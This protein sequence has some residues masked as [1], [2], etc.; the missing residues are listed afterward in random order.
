MTSNPANFFFQEH[1]GGLGWALG[2]DVWER[3]IKFYDYVKSPLVNYAWDAQISRIF[4][5]GRGNLC[6]YPEIP[7]SYHG[8]IKSTGTSVMQR[9]W[10]ENMILNN[11]SNVSYRIQELQ[12]MDHHIQSQIEAGV[13]VDCV[14]DILSYH[15]TSVVIFLSASSNFDVNWKQIGN[16]FSNMAL[17]VGEK[18]MRAV[19]KVTTQ[20]VWGTNRVLIV[21]SGSPFAHLVSTKFMARPHQVIATTCNVKTDKYWVEPYQHLFFKEIGNPDE[22]CH[23]TCAKKHQ[24]CDVHY[25]HHVTL[26]LKK[27]NPSGNIG[28]S[29]NHI[30]YAYPMMSPGQDVIF[31]SCARW[32]NCS[33]IAQPTF[34]RIC[35]CVEHPAVW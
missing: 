31:S 19:Y 17:F 27:N 7:R 30:S 35:P 5:N 14:D 11:Q 9:D 32:Y 18:P 24:H 2:R 6:I 4:D 34:R 12:K 10:F 33:A 20:F 15:N 1:F 21:G 8:F 28:C 29:Q 13:L 23:D 3:D 22:S 26:E 25:F 16:L